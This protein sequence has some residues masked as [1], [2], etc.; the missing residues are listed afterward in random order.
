MCGTLITPLGSCQTQ[1]APERLFF[2]NG[3][4]LSQ[5]IH[6]T[7]WRFVFVFVFLTGINKSII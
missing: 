4:I 6:N 2:P 7:P 5:T 1:G 3:A